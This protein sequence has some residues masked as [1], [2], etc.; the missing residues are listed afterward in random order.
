MTARKGNNWKCND[1]KTKAEILRLWRNS[2]LRVRQIAT[3]LGIPGDTSVRQVLERAGIDP[4]TKWRK[5]YKRPRIE[6]MLRE[7][8]SMEDVMATTKASKKYVQ[9][10]MAKMSLRSVVTRSATRRR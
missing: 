1:P 5:D 8:R 7:G 2:S 9:V 6:A 4:T 3:R 10:L